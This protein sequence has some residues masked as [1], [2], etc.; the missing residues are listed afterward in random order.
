MLVFNLAPKSTRKI[1][2][3][4]LLGSA[5][6]VVFGRV[7]MVFSESWRCISFLVAVVVA[8]VGIAMKVGAIA[9][10]LRIPI[11]SM[12]QTVDLPTWMV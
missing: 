3:P 2:F 5:F 4:T 1:T 9:A 11:G 7:P 12:Q 8:A 10:A 6:G